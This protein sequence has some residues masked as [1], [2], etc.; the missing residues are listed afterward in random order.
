MYVVTTGALTVILNCLVDVALA[1]AADTVNVDV[2]SEPTA[3]TEPEITAVLEF[4]D[5]PDG[6]EP[7]DIDHVPAVAFVAP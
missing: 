5:K 1:V 3:L 7:E 2:V 4:I 6:K